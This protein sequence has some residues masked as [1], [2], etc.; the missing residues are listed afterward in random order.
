MRA[1]LEARVRPNPRG[2][3]AAKAIAFGIFGLAATANAATLDVPGQ[4]GTIG[5]ALAAAAPGDVVRVAAGTYSPTANGESFPLLLNK[6]VAL[7]GAGIGASILDAEGTAGVI[8]CATTTGGRVTGFTI[9]GGIALRGGG[10]F[11]ASG[12]PE[13]DRNLIWA[14]GAELRGAGIFASSAA[15]PWIH[16]NV[17]W[18]NFDT[19]MPGA[20]DP[21]GIVLAGTTTGTV[22]HNIVGRTDGNG[23]LTDVNALPSIRHNIFFENG[24][25]S[26]LRGRGICWLSAQPPEVFHN[27]F[28]DNVINAILWPGAGGDLSGTE[29]NEVDAGDLVY[30]NLD[31]DPQ[32]TDPDSGDF[33]LLP[34]S[35]AIDAGDP[36]LPLDP[37]GTIADIGP[38]YYDQGGASDAPAVGSSGVVSASAAPNP[39]RRDTSIRFALGRPGAVSIDIV[40]VSGRRVR[41]LSAEELPAGA[42]SVSWD[43]RDDAGHSVSSG[44]WFA[45]VTTEQGTTT[46]PLVRLR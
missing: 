16:H 23:L 34:G 2:G 40:D 7:E 19:V 37:D 15:A 18:E 10:V 28:F 26:P 5:A 39:F 24:I 41:S 35:A 45:R 14:N 29:A 46:L 38:Y 22:E 27:L 21:H 4:Y 31:D 43:G 42:Q 36:A 1:N 32:L 44:V 8:T 30:G 25:T 33:A 17:V 13:I 9:T 6:D 3:A 11:V 12:D 20:Q